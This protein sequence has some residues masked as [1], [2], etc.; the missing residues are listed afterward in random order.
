MCESISNS[1]NVAHNPFYTYKTKTKLI[2]INDDKS[3][4]DNNISYQET[5][6]SIIEKMFNNN[7]SIF[8]STT[9][10]FYPSDNSKMKN[11]Y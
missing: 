2:D 6:I 9:I 1:I 10:I 3:L 5:I 4:K 7:I 11:I 8:C